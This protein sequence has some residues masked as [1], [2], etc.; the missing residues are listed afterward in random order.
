M[1]IESL[2]GSRTYQALGYNSKTWSLLSRPGAMGRECHG[3]KQL[4]SGGLQTGVGELSRFQQE[5]SR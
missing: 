3:D 5:L 2:L 4:Q 1:L